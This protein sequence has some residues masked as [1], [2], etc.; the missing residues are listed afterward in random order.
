MKKVLVVGQT[1]PPIGGQA[2]MIENLVNTSLENIEITHVRMC[3]SRGMKDM[4]KIQLWKLFHLFQ[5]ILLIYWNRMKGFDILYYPPSGPTSAVYRDILILFPTRWLFRK[6]IFHF[7]ASGLSHHLK[8]KNKWFI[9]MFKVAFMNPDLAIHLSPSCPQEGTSLRAKRC[10][11]IPNG[12]PDVAKRANNCIPK[13]ILNVLFI[14]FLEESKGE[15][16]ILE[17]MDILHKKGHLFNVRLAGE[18]KSLEYKETFMDMI[19]SRGLENEIEYRGI[20]KGC[21]KDLLFKD[22]DIFCFPSHFH[23]ESFPL[24][25]IEAME[26][27][28]PIVSTVWRGIPDMVTNG[29]NGFLV[30]IKNAQQVADKLQLIYDDFKLRTEVSM[31]ARKQ[32]EEKYSMEQHLSLMEKA[33]NCL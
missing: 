16:E 23:S 27:G 14:G 26:Y 33:I 21:E 32:F 30:D 24:V 3:F 1:P 2:V 17:A 9:W 29:Y 31:N 20:V 11:N 15:L 6:T 8:N 19:K 12:M 25:L 22:T 13:K 18:F 7:H 4:G 28:I 10:V 5:I